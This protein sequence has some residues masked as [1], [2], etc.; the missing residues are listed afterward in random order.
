MVTK[1]PTGIT[2]SEVGMTVGSF[3]TYRGTM[4]FDGLL[5]KNGKVQYRLNLM[6]QMKGTQREFEYNNRLSVAPVLKFQINPSTSLTVEYTYQY[7]NMSPIGSNYAYSARKLGD[8]PV[9]FSTLEANMAPTIIKDQSIFVTLSHSINKNWKFTGQM[10][11][12][13]YDQV[14][15]SL[16]PSAFNG[17]TLL[18][19]ISN[20]DILGQ[21]RVGQFFVNGDVETGMIKHRILAGV[22]MGDKD[23]YHDWNQGG[24]ITGSEG[25]NVYDPVYGKVAAGTYPVFDRTLNVKERGVHYNNLYSAVYVQDEIRLMKEK[26][27]LTLAGRYTTTGDEDPYSGTVKADK[28]TPRIGLSYSLNNSTSVYAVFDESFIPQAGVN[29]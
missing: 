13:H 17:D 5:N 15:A 28:F 8:L 24:A 20:W 18:R 25:F 2:K 1:K 3:G 10:A 26:L 21:T 29:F 9:D 16:W 12:M 7:V 4:D 6:G 27:R 22:D 14:G 23:F 19:G 11:Y